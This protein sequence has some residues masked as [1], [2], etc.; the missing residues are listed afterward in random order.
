MGTLADKFSIYKKFRA[1]L[2]AEDKFYVKLLGS[3]AVGVLAIAMLAAI[4]LFVAVRD[5][6]FE[7]LR[8]RTLDVLRKL[9]DTEND[10]S[11]ME[12]T[13][14]GYLLTGQ[15]TYAEAFR[16]QTALLQTQLDG[17]AAAVAPDGRESAQIS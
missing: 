13:Y 6:Q 15:Q 16:H 1:F 4:L 9:G 12:A 8:A 3:S 7:S 14:R 5:H 10:I 17:V 2:N 11:K